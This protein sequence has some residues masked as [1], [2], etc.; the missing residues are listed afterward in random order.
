MIDLFSELFGMFDDFDNVFTVNTQPKESKKCPVCSS[1]WEDFNKT[2]KFG[3]G[4]CYKVFEG[5]AE[6]VLRQIHS[7]S[8]HAGKIPSKS[9]AEV[10]AKRRLENLKKELKEAVANEDYERAAKLHNQIK[11]LEAGGIK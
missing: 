9:G 1:T 3:C 6:R 7:S 8:Q 4:E 5:G 11:E 2:G 10:K